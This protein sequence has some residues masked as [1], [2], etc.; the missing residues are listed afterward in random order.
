MIL[1]TNTI[2]NRIKLCIETTTVVLLCNWLR[3]IAFYEL[4]RNI[5]R[6]AN[7]PRD[8]NISLEWIGIYTS[9]KPIILF[10]VF[11]GDDERCPLFEKGST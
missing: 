5:Y 8:S 6:S 9:T 10:M 2:R 4:K 1:L 3:V 7:K 11:V